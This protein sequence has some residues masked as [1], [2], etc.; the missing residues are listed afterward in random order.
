MKPHAETQRDATLGE[1]RLHYLVALSLFLFSLSQRPGKCY[2]PVG[3][4][5]VRVLLLRLS[6]DHLSQLLKR[7]HATLL[8]T[9]IPEN[10]MSPRD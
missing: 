10:A 9:E 1:T 6:Q 4:S 3:D 2:F 8:S 7:R 5:R